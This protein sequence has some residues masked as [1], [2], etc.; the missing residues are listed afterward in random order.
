MEDRMLIKIK[1]PNDTLPLYKASCNRWVRD[2]KNAIQYPKNSNRLTYEHN[3]L[4]VSHPDWNPQITETMNEIGTY[5]ST[6]KPRLTFKKIL[7]NTGIILIIPFVIPIVAFLT[8]KDKII[9]LC[10]KRKQ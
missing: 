4:Y 1:R 5:I 6:Y 3:L 9:E 2:S 7:T 10:Q 8:I